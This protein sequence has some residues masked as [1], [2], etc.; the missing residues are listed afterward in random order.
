MTDL[1]KRETRTPTTVD[2]FDRFFDEWAGFWPVRRP[3]WLGFERPRD[4]MIR[5]DEFR[6]GETLV[7]HAEL[8]GIDP[9]KDVEVTVTDGILH[10]HAERREEHKEDDGGV[11]RRE[12]RY[13][14]FSRTLPLP[15]GA[16]ADDI[17]A[18]YKDG[19]LEVRIPTPK[20]SA[21]KVP[22]GKG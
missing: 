8:P 4:E 21:T 6:D 19:M 16:K 7:V 3:V 11:N 5:V 12:L 18:T 1:V 14:S 17:E 2:F 15:P 20:S 13:G 10:L 9:E 22:V